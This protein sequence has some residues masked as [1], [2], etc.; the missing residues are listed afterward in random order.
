MRVYSS[1][2]VADKSGAILHRSREAAALVGYMNGNHPHPGCLTL[3]T[4]TR[5]HIC[6]KANMCDVAKGPNV[7]CI[8]PV[9]AHLRDGDLAEGPMVDDLEGEA[10]LAPDYLE[11][12]VEKYVPYPVKILANI[13]QA[14][15]QD[16]Q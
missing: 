10:E 7:V 12:L 15:W 3:D 13:M 14:L 4:N 11:E 9:L 6:E 5:L 2:L 8:Q 16:R 1:L